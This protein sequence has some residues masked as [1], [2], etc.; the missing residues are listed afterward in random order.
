MA[1]LASTRGAPPEVRSLLTN[2][3]FGDWDVSD[4]YTVGDH[5]I[6]STVEG[7]IA[8]ALIALKAL[9]SFKLSN[10]AGGAP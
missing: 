1:A 5:L 3:L 4:R 10:M 8:G 6:G 2:D 7:H 9:E